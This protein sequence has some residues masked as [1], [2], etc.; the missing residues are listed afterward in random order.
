MITRPGRGDPQGLP[1]ELVVVAALLAAVAVAVLVTYSRIASAELYNVSHGGVTGGASRTLVFLNYPT[2]LVAIGA[3]LLL[4]DRLAGAARATAIAGIVL[5]AAVFWPGVVDQGDLDAKPV[6]AIAAAGV[7]LAVVVAG[8]VLVNDFWHEQVV[9]RC[10]TS[11]GIP[12][13]TRPSISVAWGVVVLAA[14]ALWL[15]RGGMPPIHNRGKP[16]GS[17]PR[18]PGLTGSR[19]G[20][21]SR[22]AVIERVRRSVT[23]ARAG[24]PVALRSAAV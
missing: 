18:D 17:R 2:A 15:S 3:L 11:W 12:N 16:P 24:Q 1:R 13:V 22:R 14:A 10:W 9:K 4:V 7:A 20:S 8:V 5:C 19:A 21:T 6:N 23:D